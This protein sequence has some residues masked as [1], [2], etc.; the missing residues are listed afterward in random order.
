M[1]AAPAADAPATPAPLTQIAT[2]DLARHM[3]TW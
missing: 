3:G 2:L 1:L